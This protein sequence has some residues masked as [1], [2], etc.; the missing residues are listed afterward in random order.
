MYARSTTFL[1]EP[2]R[3]DDGVA[4]VRTEVGPTLEAIDGCTGLSMI[5]S[6]DRKR[7]IVTSGWRDEQAQRDSEPQAQ[8]LRARGTEIFGTVAKVDVWEI[9][10]LH[11]DHDT[12]PGGCLRATW[13]R[14][15]PSR[16]ERSIDNYRLT[17]LPLFEELPGFCSASL[18]VDRAS[19]RAV[20]SVTYDGHDAML[21][22]RELATSMRRTAVEENAL[23]LLEVV[24]FTVDLAR[25]RAPEMV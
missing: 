21:R 11:R 2:T 14:V 18:F 22:S 1:T 15:D 20:S 7:A 13:T 9:A 6:T 4:Y 16:V 12:P 17:L 10:V 25:L 24:E 8:P 19:G 5:V 23:E 3:M